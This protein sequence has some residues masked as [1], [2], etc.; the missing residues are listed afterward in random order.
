MKKII[1]ILTMLLLSGCAASKKEMK[2]YIV[3]PTQQ[4]LYLN[5][6]EEDADEIKGIIDLFTGNSRECDPVTGGIPFYVEY[7]NLVYMI[8]SGVI[9]I[10]KNNEWKTYEAK[11]SRDEI[12][13]YT[14]AI[15]KIC[16][17]TYP[18]MFL[19]VM[20]TFGKTA[21]IKTGEITVSNSDTE[22]AAFMTD[23]YSSLYG[24]YLHPADNADANEWKLELL[25]TDLVGEHI[26]FL[27]DNQIKAGD[28]IYLSDFSSII[29]KFQNWTGMEKY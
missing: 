3:V 18:G 2:A 7:D 4:K 11:I 17:K 20:E 21:E 15:V 6:S 24:A 12:A 26:L 14:L 27:N 16:Q 8:T 25:F 22:G 9:S 1:I 10:R 23:F 29:Q 28:N 5:L 13:D 19:D